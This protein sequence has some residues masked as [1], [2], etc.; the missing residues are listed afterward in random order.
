MVLQRSEA[1]SQ[2]PTTRVT[3]KVS[4]P[5]VSSHITVRTKWVVDLVSL[6]RDPVDKDNKEASNP[7]RLSSLSLPGYFLD[8]HGPKIDKAEYLHHSGV[9]FP[10]II[11]MRLYPRTS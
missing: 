11:E 3:G 2:T 1:L 8:I 10:E 5:P 7:K 4:K 6:R 9:N